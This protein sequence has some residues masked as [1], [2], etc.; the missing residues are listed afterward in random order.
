[1][2]RGSTFAVTWANRGEVGLSMYRIEKDG[3]LIGE[4]TQLGAIGIVNR[5]N[6]TPKRAEGTTT[7][8][9]KK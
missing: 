2:R 5:E 4:Y 6:L 9:E 7:K 1:M 3:R 8:A